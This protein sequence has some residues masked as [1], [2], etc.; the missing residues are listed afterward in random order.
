MWE[1][2]ALVR[3]EELEREETSSNSEMSLLSEPIV[4][5]DD[6]S[7]RQITSLACDAEGKHYCCGKDD[8]TVNIHEMLEGKKVRKAYS[9][10][11][12]VSIISLAWSLSDKYMVSGDDPGRVIAK[13]LE[14]REP[15]KW[16]VYPIF[17]I[18]LG[19]PVE[20][21]IFHPSEKLL[22]ISTR[23]GDRVWNLRSKKE[24][25]RRCWPSQN[26]RRWISHPLEDT[27][28]LWIDPIEVQRFDW[29]SLV[30]FEKEPNSPKPEA[31]TPNP[32][33]QKAPESAGRPALPHP[34]SRPSKA[35]DNV[36]WMSRTKNGRY[37]I[38]ETLPDTGHS[39][40]ASARGM[41]IELL[42]TSGLGPNQG[43]KVT[44]TKS[45]PIIETCCAS[46]R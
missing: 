41:R 19:E 33:K 32:V 46:D 5:R 15:G 34:S 24:L 9:H 37:I 7:R 14:S 30:C 28:L 4:S 8:G 25:C 44:L 12:T 40:A 16:M 43:E 45:G 2:D 27:V 3:P 35:P 39:R 20:Q 31:S 42:P 23:L 13:P 11:T 21:F 17:D 38:C 36:N 22:L 1:P 6:N 18:R 29:E 10:A 26:G